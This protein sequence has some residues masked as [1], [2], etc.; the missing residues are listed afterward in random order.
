MS[1]LP[2][3]TRRKISRYEPIN[4]SGIIL[5][6]VRVL[7]LEEFNL[8]RPALE[9]LQQSLPVTMLSVPLLQAYYTIDLESIVDEQMPSGLWAR[10][11]LF[12][13]LS[14]RLGDGMTPEE[15][16]RLFRVINRDGDIYRL[17]AL[18]YTL[19][20]HEWKEITPA[21]FQAMRPVLAAQNGIELLPDEANPELVQAERDVRSRNAPD[22]D[23]RIDTMISTVATLMRVDDREIY[24]WPI[25]K[26]QRRQ[27]DIQRVLDYLV[28]AIGEAQGTKWK[29][30]NPVPSPFFNRAKATNAGA[31]SLSEFA[32]GA[33]QA[34]V[35]SAAR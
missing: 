11:L 8:A 32:G 22:M 16:I 12:L 3:K 7:E 9:F 35:R 18:T 17:Q 28:C 2:L 25:L 13:A 1:E 21:A 31:V 10:A 29:S 30:G 20:G 14:L 23:A 5:H 34:A 24:E 4:M 6:P 19:D 26:L 33:A 27:E 15:R